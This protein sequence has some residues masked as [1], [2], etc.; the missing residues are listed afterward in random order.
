M[1]TINIELTFT[2]KT[3]EKHRK[4]NEGLRSEAHEDFLRYVRD[5]LISDLQYDGYPP[6]KEKAKYVTKEK[7]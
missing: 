2:E 1:R 7:R 6:K 4:D 5:S 3:I